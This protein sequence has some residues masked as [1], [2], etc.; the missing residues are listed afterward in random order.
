[1]VLPTIHTVHGMPV[2][3]QVF[4]LPCGNR[5]RGSVRVLL[6]R[7][8][9]RVSRLSGLSHREFYPAASWASLPTT[10][11]HPS[12]RI[13]KQDATFVHTYPERSTSRWHADRSR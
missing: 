13:W 6:L 9:S 8:V 3:Y 11:Y 5:N 7:T 1:M 10:D 4:L 2:R 12:P